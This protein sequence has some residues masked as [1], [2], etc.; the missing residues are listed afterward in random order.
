MLLAAVAEDA[1]QA[2][3]R[4]RV[5]LGDA[6]LRALRHCRQLG[7]ADIRPAADQIGG[8]AD[9][10]V[11]G[12]TGIPLDPLQQLVHRLRRHAEQ[13][14]Q[15]VEPLV[16]WSVQLRD[17]RFGLAEDVLR[18]VDVELGRGA[19]AVPRLGDRQRLSLL[20]DVFA[21]DLDLRLQW[22]GCRY[23]LS[24]RRRAA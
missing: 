5:G 18:L 15:R 1:G 22:C 19:A 8:N 24:R 14:A 7:G 20:D 3:S 23:R 21:G 17:R 12:G 9:R 16:S 11:V 13:H 2:E 6:D 4:D 10:D